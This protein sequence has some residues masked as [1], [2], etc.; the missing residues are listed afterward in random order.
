MVESW[1]NEG[2]SCRPSSY[3]L[4][5]TNTVLECNLVSRIRTQEEGTIHNGVLVDRVPHRVVAEEDLQEVQT[6]RWQP[7]LKMVEV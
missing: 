2:K 4:L 6:I 3:Y 1:S 7:Q 5:T